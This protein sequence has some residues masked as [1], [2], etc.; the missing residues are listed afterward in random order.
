MLAVLAGCSRD[1]PEAPP[2]AE[3][4]AKSAPD[5]E[6]DTFKKPKRLWRT[7]KRVIDGC[8]IELDGGEKV[9]LIG[10]RTTHKHFDDKSADFIRKTLQRK[11][12]WL[13]YDK[14]GV[15]HKDKRLRTLAYVRYTEKGH[16]WV[17]VPFP[18]G[19]VEVREAF[20]KHY[21]LN[22]EI[23]RKGLG[24]VD[25]EYPFKELDRYKELEKEARKARKGLWAFLIDI[26]HITDGRT[27][28][29][30]VTSE[31]EDEVLLEMELGII[32][33]DRKKVARIERK[34]KKN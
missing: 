19:T 3:Q 18:N 16:G 24:L 22:E 32:R 9:R 11:K 30:W 26:V 27:L 4:P 13:Q 23:I 29:G 14:E 1:E 6:L 7:V 5:R 12:V 31:T 25:T 15:L 34:Q 17:E 10:V 21:V 8:A 2:Q 20:D 33:I 28:K